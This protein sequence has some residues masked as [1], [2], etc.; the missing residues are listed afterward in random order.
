MAWPATSADG[1]PESPR[2]HLADALGHLV[3]DALVCLAQLAETFAVD[4]DHLRGLGRPGGGGVDVRLHHRSPAEH[5]PRTELVDEDLATLG[6]A[7]LDRRFAFQK[8]VESDRPPPP[9]W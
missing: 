6:R 3:A 4:D 2:D 7:Y 8:E 1:L 9:L 5:L